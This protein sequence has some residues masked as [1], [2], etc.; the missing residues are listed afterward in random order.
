MDRARNG[1][2][3]LAAHDLLKDLPEDVLDLFGRIEK[4]AQLEGLY[5]SETPVL[6][7]GRPGKLDDSFRTG[8]EIGSAPAIFAASGR[9][10]ARGQSVFYGATNLHGAV[11]EMANHHGPDVELWCGRF[12]PSRSLFHLDVMRVPESPSPF[13]PGAANTFDAISFLIRFAETLREPKPARQEH[14][15]DDDYW[16]RLDRHYLP[17][18]VFTAF[19]LG[20]YEDLRPDA[21]KYGSS[22]D[23]SSENWV[24]FADHDHCTDVGDTTLSEDNVCLFLD[25]QTVRFVAARDFFNVT[26]GSD[27]QER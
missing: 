9:L 16:V 3:K 23:P 15:E 17:T 18:Q 14:E 27:R 13:A 4:Y 21:I 8:R 2:V 25:P 7:R 12:T 24:V 6:W 11:I 1:Q 20:T 22:L 26:S 10:N 19:L 5:R